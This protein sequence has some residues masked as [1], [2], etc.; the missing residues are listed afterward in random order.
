MLRDAEAGR[1]RAL[2]V[3][4]EAST[5]GAALDL[6][7]RLLKVCKDGNV[8]AATLLLRLES[9]PD[10]NAIGRIESLGLT[11]PLIAAASCGSLDL[12]DL[13][14]K[15]HAEPNLAVGDANTKNA[16]YVVSQL[17][18]SNALRSKLLNLLCDAARKKQ[19][20]ESATRHLGTSAS[21]FVPAA[22]SPPGTLPDGSPCVLS[23]YE[24]RL[25]LSMAAPAPP[26]SFGS[27]VDYAEELNDEGEEEEAELDE[28]EMAPEM[29]PEPNV[30]P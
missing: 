19:L 10:V 21:T 24:L 28:A 9:R 14:L 25:A 18:E 22:G 8:A 6:N 20:D 29:A 5:H 2:D 17:P 3:L 13:L 1:R 12:V 4:K 26:T 27:T 11:S 16:I 7:E 30:N 23:P 15:N